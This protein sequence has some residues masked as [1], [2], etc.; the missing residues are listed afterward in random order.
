MIRVR[1]GAIA[2]TRKRERWHNPV[3]LVAHL[4]LQKCL[5]TL[6]CRP[7]V[8]LDHVRETA[9]MSRVLRCLCVLRTAWAPT[10]LQSECSAVW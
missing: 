7:N 4:T 10:G 5:A 6:V 2:L 3:T 9:G 8:C 1:L